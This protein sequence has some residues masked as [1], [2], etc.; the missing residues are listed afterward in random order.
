MS[1]RFVAVWSLSR[2]RLRR[3]EQLLAEENAK[4]MA[5]AAADG[6]SWEHGVKVPKLPPEVARVDDAAVVWN[7]RQAPVYERKSRIERLMQLAEGK[8]SA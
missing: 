6:V 2:G 3:P 4:V 7:P 1:T 5:A 8:K